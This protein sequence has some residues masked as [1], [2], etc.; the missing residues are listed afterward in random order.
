MPFAL[1]DRAM[2]FLTHN[3]QS[4]VVDDEEASSIPWALPLATTPAHLVVGALT[5]AI[6]NK[7]NGKTDPLLRRVALFRGLAPGAVAALYARAGM[8]K[9]E[10]G[11][12][13]FKHGGNARCLYVVLSGSVD[14]CDGGEPQERVLPGE[15]FGEEALWCSTSLTASA[16]AV[17]PSCLLRFT[18]ADLTQNLPLDTAVR[19]ALNIAVTL[20]W[21]LAAQRAAQARDA[22]AA[23]ECQ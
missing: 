21:R 10:T 16:H 1:R 5:G 9:Y 3:T 23:C 19:V 20:N 13:I 17:E 8:A 14:V 18:L 2:D 7:R 4:S 22:A 15:T 11:D 12:V 6:L